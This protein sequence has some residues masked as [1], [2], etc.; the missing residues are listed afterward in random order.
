ME[1]TNVTPGK[2]KMMFNVRNSTRT[3]KE[4]IEIFVHHY[5]SGMNYDLNLS[6]SAK[7]FLTDPGT[8]VVEILDHAIESVCGIRPQ[9]STAG[10]TSDARFLAEYGVKTVE[11]GVVNDSIH[12]PNE[13]T[14]IDEV[15]KLYQVF[16]KMI[17]IFKEKK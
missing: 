10:G 13:H 11:F 16:G 4:D 1:V 2:L 8:A 5:F 3:S 9:H 17:K 7:P 6:Q 12:A 14:T 15:E